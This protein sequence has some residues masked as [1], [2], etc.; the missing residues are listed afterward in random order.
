[1]MMVVSDSLNAKLVLMKTFL[2]PVKLRSQRG[3]RALESQ[4]F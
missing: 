4:L 1:M 3:T 2:E